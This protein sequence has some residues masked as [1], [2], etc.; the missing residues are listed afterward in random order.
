[1]NRLAGLG[2]G[3]GLF[4]HPNQ[5]LLITVL[6]IDKHQIKA[7]DIGVQQ[8]SRLNGLKGHEAL[9]GDIGGLALST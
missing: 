2:A 4:D 9:A 1:M 7:G 5:D 8:K 6:V 3:T